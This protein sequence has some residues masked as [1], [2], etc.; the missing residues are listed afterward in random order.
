[1]VVKTGLLRAAPVDFLAVTRN[2]HEQGLGPSRLGADAAGHLQAVH[3]GQPDV[4]QHDLRP[5]FGNRLERLA[6][7]V[8]GEHFVSGVAEYQRQAEGGVG[9]G[10][11]QKREPAVAAK[12]AESADLDDAAIAFLRVGDGSPLRDEAGHPVFPGFV[13]KNRPCELGDASVRPGNVPTTFVE[14]FSQ[15]IIA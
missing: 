2:G 3:V 15:A 8:Y 1:M 9:I 13:G 5:Q 10:I 4:Q 14:P 7:A 11:G 6:A 12:A